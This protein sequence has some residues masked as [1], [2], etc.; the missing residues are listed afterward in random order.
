MASVLALAS[1]IAGRQ[2]RRWEPG[3]VAVCTTRW[4]AEDPSADLLDLARQ[5]GPYPFLCSTLSFAEA[6][7]GGL[8]RYEEGLVKEGVGAGGA[9]VAATLALGI[10]NR[11]LLTAI[12]TFCDELFGAAPA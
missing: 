1:A 7:H 3:D 8:R 5:I 4:V 12:D 2:A 9:A 6:R 11:T 10:D